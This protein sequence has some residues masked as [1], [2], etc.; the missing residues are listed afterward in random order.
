MVATLWLLGGVVVAYLGWSLYRRFGADRLAQFIERR[1]GGSRIVGRGEFVDGNRHLDVAL[2]VTDSTLFYE[3]S[4]MQASLELRW[5]REIEYDTELATGG[6]VTGGRVLRLRSDSQT[7]E[8][9]VPNES[10]TRWQLA[11]PS[12]GPILDPVPQ[13]SAAR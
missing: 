4:D 5:I 12:R 9:V 13:P 1:R 3:N 2:A 10:A 11:L 8:F 7:F 6:A